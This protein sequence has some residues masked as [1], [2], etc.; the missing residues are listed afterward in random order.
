MCFSPYLQNKDGQ[1]QPASSPKFLPLLSN[2]CMPY[3]K[4]KARPTLPRRSWPPGQPSAMLPAGWDAA[5][6]LRPAAAQQAGGAGRPQLRHRP[7]AP[8]VLRQSCAHV[9]PTEG[10]KT[11][12]TWTSREDRAQRSSLAPSRWAKRAIVKH[13]LNPA[14]AAASCMSPWVFFSH[15]CQAWSWIQG[16][17]PGLALLTQNRD[18]IRAAAPPVSQGEGLQPPWRWRP[19]APSLP[20]STK[21]TWQ[22]LPPRSEETHSSLGFKWRLQDGRGNPRPTVLC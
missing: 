22:H 17:S 12:N 14:A 18:E 11:V 8:V 21:G 7:G 13:G 9:E 4:A 10:R 16:P 19:P 1:R 2:A 15:S 3:S 5:G 6:G 20:I